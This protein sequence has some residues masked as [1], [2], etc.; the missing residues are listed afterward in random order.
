MVNQFPICPLLAYNDASTSLFLYYRLNFAYGIGID[1][2]I[3]LFALP[4]NS[5][6]NSS[7]INKRN[8]LASSTR[9]R[10]L[11]VLE[12]E[13]DSQNG[14]EEKSAQFALYEVI[15]SVIIYFLNAFPL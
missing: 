1:T 5:I 9:Y 6:S 4:F 11:F 15:Q 14:G 7:A 12:N 3:Y 10:I 13:C 8:Y 2:F